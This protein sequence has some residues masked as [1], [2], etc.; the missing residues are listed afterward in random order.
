MSIDKSFNGKWCW[1]KQPKCQMWPRVASGQTNR[2]NL[3]FFFLKDILFQNDIC[4]NLNKKNGPFV[5]MLE[6][7]IQ[8]TATA[9]IYLI[10]FGEQVSESHVRM[11][12]DSSSM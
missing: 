1:A 8:S 4:F 6:D 7:L 5:C 12:M 3:K 11:N 9:A 2:K 10:I